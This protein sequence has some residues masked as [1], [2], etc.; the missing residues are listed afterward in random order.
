MPQ[1]GSEISSPSKCQCNLRS[2]QLKSMNSFDF[3]DKSF[4]KISLKLLE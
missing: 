4:V 1:D 3:M 2:S